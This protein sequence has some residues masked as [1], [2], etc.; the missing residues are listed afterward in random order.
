MA[1]LLKSKKVT[2]IQIHESQRTISTLNPKKFT[3]RYVKKNGFFFELLLYNTAP[4]RLSADF[5][6]Y[7]LGESR[8]LYSKY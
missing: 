2:D 4:I 6:P 5:S 3:L 7:R 1:E 8:S